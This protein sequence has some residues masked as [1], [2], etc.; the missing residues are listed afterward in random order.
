MEEFRNSSFGSRGIIC[1][2]QSQAGELFEKL[3]QAGEEVTLLDF[4]STSCSQGIVVTSVHMSKGLEFDQVILP[5]VS[6]QNYRTQMEQ[7]LLYIACTRAMH[8]LDVT[9]SG[10]KSDFLQ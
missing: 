10:K 9:C 1:K 2:S 5:G 8:R 4:E 3:Q 7:S 6:Q